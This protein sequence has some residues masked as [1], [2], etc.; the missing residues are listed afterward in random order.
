[1]MQEVQKSFHGR[2]IAALEPD[3]SS[4]ESTWSDTIYRMA[5]KPLKWAG[6][7]VS[8]PG[9]NH[10]ECIGLSYEDLKHGTAGVTG[11]SLAFCLP[12]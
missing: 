10:P 1:M 2:H 11:P 5:E 3:Q 6:Y 7:V 12:A 9:G 8:T 4:S